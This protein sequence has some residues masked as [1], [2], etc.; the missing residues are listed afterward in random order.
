MTTAETNVQIFGLRPDGRGKNFLLE[1]SWGSGSEWISIGQK[2]ITFDPV[3]IFE[4][5]K[6]LIAGKKLDI[7]MTY[8]DQKSHSGVFLKK[9]PKLTT[10]RFFVFPGKQIF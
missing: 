5:C 4:F 9:N 8:Q 6:K 3:N 1:L 7:T 2:S 10:F